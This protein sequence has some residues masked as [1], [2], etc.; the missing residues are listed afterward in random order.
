M[1][2]SKKKK[3]EKRS[4]LL[5]G[6]P[7]HQLHRALQVALDVYVEETG[8]GA[9]TQRQFAVLSAVSA[10]EGLTQSDL[11]RATGIDRSTL[12]ELVARMLSKG[13]L[14]RERSE[15]DA[16]ANAVRLSEAGRAAMEEIAPKVAAAD[17]RIL[18]LLGK[19]RRS[20]F[21]KVLRELADKRAAELAATADGAAPAEAKPAKGK[22]PKK[23]K[24]AKKSAKSKSDATAGP[25]AATSA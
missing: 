5:D 25:G 18:S 2:K 8:K 19:S 15:T 4:S 9:L 16:R 14:A 24:K 3:A 22:K 23:A 6:S 20:S 12:A 17:A 11:V 21:L 7:S 10:D 1:V 13:L